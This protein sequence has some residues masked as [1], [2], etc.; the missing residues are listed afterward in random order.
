MLICKKGIYKL[1]KNISHIEI[2]CDNVILDGCGMSIENESTTAGIV[3]YKGV[4]NVIMSNL[5]ITG[6]KIFLQGNNNVKINN[7]KIRNGLGLIVRDSKDV[8]IDECN[9]I[10]VGIY[11]N[12][13]E[14]KTFGIEINNTE[15]ISLN[16]ITIDGCVGKE[17]SVAVFVSDSSIKINDLFVTDVF[18]YG[19][20]KAFYHTNSDIIA[21]NYFETSVISKVAFNDLINF[22]ET[23][24]VKE[25]KINEIREEDSIK[26]FKHLKGAIEN[27]EELLEKL[28]NEHYWREFR[29][30]KRKVCHNSMKKS[31]T[32]KKCGE[33]LEKFCK[34]KLGVKIKVLEAFANLYENGDVPLPL[35]RDKYEK[36]IIGLSFG[37]TRTLDFVSDFDPNKI[38]S[39]VLEDGD[40]FIFSPSI[41]E[42]YQHR[43][44][45]E[46]ERKGKRINV[47][48]FV[49][50]IEGQLI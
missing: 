42:T 48:Y 17:L 18:S 49:D 29:T 11:K 13:I 38:Y 28:Y 44:L 46:P 45:K 3:L 24:G 12:I 23:H 27:N 41:N 25:K 6:G 39:F 50:V 16:K 19:D 40:I 20:S 4:Q 26:N 14:N 7:I 2:S 30:M 5:T 31:E 22:L 35:H 10:K 33:W 37:E 1:D 9:L 15:N 36:W 21:N 8:I 32:S 47:T 34:E 43:M